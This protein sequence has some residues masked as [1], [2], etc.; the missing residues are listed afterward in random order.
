MLV[1]VLIALL[2]LPL[3]AAGCRPAAVAAAPAGADEVE[4]ALSELE[5]Y[6]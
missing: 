1:R 5:E 4:E 6:A 3:L 2:V